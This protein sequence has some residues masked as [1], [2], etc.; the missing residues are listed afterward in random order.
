MQST[1]N[2]QYSVL[3]EGALKE[4]TW[5]WDDLAAMCRAGRM[6]PESL[7]FIPEDNGWKKLHDTPLA[8]HFSA[9]SATEAADSR[10]SS[11]LEDI[12]SRYD[13]LIGEM[14]ENPNDNDLTLH[15]AELALAKGDVEA[16]CKHYQRALEISPYHPR[17][18]QEAKRNLPASKWRTLR[19]LDKPPHVGE[20]PL[21]VLAF[22]F[23]RG[24]LYFIIPAVVLAGLSL[25][26]W[27][28]IPAVFVMALWAIETTRSSLSNERKPPLWHGVAKDPS[29][30]MLKPLLAVIINATGLLL[31]FAVI[32]GVL[33][34]M[35]KGAGPDIVT[36][37]KKSPVMMVVAVTV[38]MLCFPAVLSIAASANKRLIDMINPRRITDAIRVMELEYL[39]AVLFNAALLGVT[40]W[41]GSLFEAV[42][43]FGRVFY[44]SAAVYI[45]LAGGFV[46]G[47]VYARFAERLDSPAP[48]VQSGPE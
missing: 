23:A 35:G 19:F 8:E 11:Q 46:I 14:N 22:P 5:E 45:L 41:A 43:V 7:V 16:A 4:E 12:S 2:T 32:A 30:R 18:G 1:K 34:V 20:D 28:L 6:S 38:V 26:M 42:P 25:T 3:Q 9:D 17:V 39:S 31:P 48:A 40:W 15:A 36:T 47:R 10:E 37:I 44:A 13:A 27:A 33:L 21:A 29:S 24:P